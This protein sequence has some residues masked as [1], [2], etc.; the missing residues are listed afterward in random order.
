MNET[1]SKTD[2]ILDAAL[3][4]FVRFGFRKATMADIAR[5]AK[6]S[7]ASLYLCFS[8]KEELFRAGS[9][10]AHSRTMNDVTAALDRPGSVFDRMTA[11]IRA[12]QEGL[13]A[14]FGGSHNADE[15]FAAG[16][17]LARDIA[18]EARAR[19]LDLLITALSEAEKN[20]EID[21]TAL[22]TQATELAALVVAAMDGI[23][24][25][26][27]TGPEFEGGIRLFMALLKLG[28]APRLGRT[29]P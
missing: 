25:T 12:F 24:H 21:L 8:S 27:G 2:L 3:P 19:L 4:V 16:N 29:D 17:E 20:R 22:Q 15:L 5:A 26:H 7:R 13:I 6:I 1:D 14:P 28:T 10:R 11:G 23:K 18:L 9:K